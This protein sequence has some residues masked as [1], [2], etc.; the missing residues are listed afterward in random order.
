MTVHAVTF[1]WRSVELIDAE[2]IVTRAMAMVPLAR[3]GNLAGRQ[4]SEGEQYTLTPI[5]ERSMASHNQFF[6]SINGYYDNLPEKIAARWPSS[7]HFRRW[8]LVETGWFDEKEFDMASEKHAKM[9]GTFIRTEDEYARIV[10]RGTKV[11]VRR[12]KSQSL[13]A[14]GKKDFQASKEAVLGLAEHLVG[15][16]PSTMM[17]NAG[18]HA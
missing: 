3:Y 4:F 7:T 12:A 14:M 2:G 18:H 11:I 15:V 1:V 16:N 9:L 10:V 5:E 6:A 8:C 13:A 17:K